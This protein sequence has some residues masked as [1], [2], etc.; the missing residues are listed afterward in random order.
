MNGTLDLA[1]WLRTC[2]FWLDAGESWRI[3]V[4]A[5]EGRWVLVTFLMVCLPLLRRP[6]LEVRFWHALQDNLCRWMAA[7]S[8]RMVTAFPEGDL[9]PGWAQMLR[10]TYF[11]GHPLYPR[12]AQLQIWVGEAQRFA[13]ERRLL[14]RLWLFRM[15]LVV[16][17]VALLR[18]VT[19]GWLGYQEPLSWYLDAL[20][21]LWLVLGFWVAARL[22]PATWL[23][24]QGAVPEPVLL[25]V[26]PQQAAVSP[27]GKAV[28]Q[29][30]HLA[31]Q[32]GYCGDAVLRQLC[33]SR[34]QDAKVA[35]EEQL[36]RCR[37]TLG[38]VEFVVAA[39]ILVCHLGV[40]ASEWHLA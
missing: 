16:V 39:G 4:I 33:Q 17:V 22:Q 11:A 8:D 15:V 7:V 13:G 28:Q 32:A 38:L 37:T 9:W 25:L 30:V 1:A 27:W 23:P 34:L 19:C 40:V 10:G 31:E 12:L 14:G 24:S 35:A 18:V 29:K 26:A 36:E 3:M 2:A 21:G 20:A 6:P 5:P